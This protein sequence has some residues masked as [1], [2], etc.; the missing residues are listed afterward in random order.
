LPF[1]MGSILRHFRS[2]F[3]EPRL[4]CDESRQ[5]VEANR[6]FDTCAAS[7]SHAFRLTSQV[8]ISAFTIGAIE[9]STARW[10]PRTDHRRK[11]LADIPSAMHADTHPRST[12]LHGHSNRKFLVAIRRRDRVPQFL[13]IKLRRSES[14]R[15]SIR[16]QGALVFSRADIR[17]IRG[18]ILKR[19][20]TSRGT[21]F[22]ACWKMA[23]RHFIVN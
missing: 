6:M 22:F 18:A 23:R 21:K 9:I 4:I 17:S 1:A 5:E 13:L 3:G 11:L 16:C 8:A 20:D 19:P 10:P 2:A 14:A 12:K 15:G 7:D